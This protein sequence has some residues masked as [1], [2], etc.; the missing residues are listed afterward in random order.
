MTWGNVHD[1]APEYLYHASTSSLVLSSAF[2]LTSTISLDTYSASRK[3]VTLTTLMSLLSVLQDLFEYR[4]ASRGYDGHCGYLR[5]QR[6]GDAKA[7]Y[8]ETPSVKRPATR[9]STPNSFSTRTEIM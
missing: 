9:A 7:L 4:F 2:T 5:G 1:P 8:I 6:L 3:S